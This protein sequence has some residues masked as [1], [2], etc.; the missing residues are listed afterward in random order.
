M[1]ILIVGAGKGSFTMRAV[2]LGA[3]LGARVTGSP[4]DADWAW[5]SV[6]ILIKRAG[7]Q[8]A[9]RAHRAKVP[10]VWD[11]LDFWSQ[12]AHNSVTPEGARILLQQKIAEIRPAL[13]I[14]ATDA[15]A[16]AAGGVCLPHHGHIDLR[17][18]PVRSA[19][20]SVGYDGNA[21]YL[22]R[23]TP[24]L[25]K[26]CA[27]RG[28]SFV[29]NPESLTQV[30]IVVALRGG[31]WDGWICRQWKS[32][33]K[34]GNAI[35]AG[36]PLISQASAAVSELRPAGTVIETPADLSAALDYWTPLERRESV[37][38]ASRER[39]DEFTVSTAAE[40]YRAIL[41]RV[42]LAMEHALC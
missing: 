12:P 23:W 6:A 36:R 22:D 39:V 21:L 10:I 17:P 4:T 3:A 41:D 14:G 40:R 7:A 37:Y 34:V 28:W 25:Q 29:V 33:V 1:N 8:Y 42:A 15:M 24:I 32:G 18:A 19:V 35:L 5:A 13:T 30:D 11:A 20:Q 16:E 27:D 38:H 26:A 9:E 31:Q 2:Q